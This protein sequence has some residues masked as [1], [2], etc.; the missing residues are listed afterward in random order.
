[1]PLS[2]RTQQN[3][4][5]PMPPAPLHTRPS[6]NNMDSPMTPSSPGFLSPQQTP[7]GSPSKHQQPPGSY[8]LPNVFDNA[9]KLAPSGNT[10]TKIPLRKQNNGNSPTKDPFHIA[11]DSDEFLPD[12]ATAGMPGSPTRKSNKENTP[13][14]HRPALVEKSSFLTHAQSARQ[15]P[16][17]SRED[18]APRQQTTSSVEQPR[19]SPEEIEKL[20]KPSVKRLA[21]VTQL[22]KWES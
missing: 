7:Q 19:L 6:N 16:Y 18:L 9:L 17:K 2:P 10:P 15:A 20:Q 12:Y 3:F 22:C 8:D 11:E 4:Q 14:S 1:M 5:L 13:P 21:N